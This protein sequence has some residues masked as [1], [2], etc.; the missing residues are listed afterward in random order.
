MAPLEVDPGALDG[1]GSAVAAVGEGLGLVI[2]TLTGALS[3][4]AGMAGNDPAGAALGRSYDSSASKLIQAMAT[5]R[6]GL[7]KIGDGVRM[8]AHN[9]S[10]AEAMSNVSGRSDPIPMPPSTGSISAGSSPSAV[11][12][13]SSAPAGWGWV[14][15][16]IGMIW[17]NGDSAKLRA[18]AAAWN[19]AGT[20]FLVG[21]KFG[22]AGPLG[23]VRAQQIPEAEAIAN[24]LTDSDRSCAAIKQQCSAIADQ[25]NAY[26]ARIEQVHAA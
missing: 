24:A 12:A 13:G 21:Q 26:A 20:E 8:S 17:P 22:L 18:A 4:C 16:Y 11:G 10:V 19:A 2:S 15:P 1:A 23:T 5:A 7:C 14:A 9:Y 25:L 3:G 6:N